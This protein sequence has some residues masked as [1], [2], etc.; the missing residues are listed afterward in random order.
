MAEPDHVRRL[1][2]LGASASEPAGRELAA[3]ELLGCDD[4]VVDRELEGSLLRAVSIAWDDGWQPAEL[5]RHVRRMDGRAGRVA[6]SAVL[7]DHSVRHAGTLDRRWAAQVEAIDAPAVDR[8]TGWLAALGRREHL[9]RLD[10]LVLALGT[11]AALDAG[12]A[13]ADDPAPARTGWCATVDW[14]DRRR[15]SAGQGARPA[16]P[17]RV[18]HVRG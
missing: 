8:P 9:R 14:S 7:A 15:S 11:L 5:V 16:R 6:A 17:G 13:A 4:G 1:V 2:A 18:D 10:L 3:G 12:G